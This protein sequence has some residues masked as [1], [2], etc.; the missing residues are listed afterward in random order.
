MIQQYVP[1]PDG[2]EFGLYTLGDHLPDPGTGSRISARQRLQEIISLATL[3]EQAGLDSFSVGE[4][5]Q[6]GF[7]TQAHAVV[8]AAIAQATSRIRIFS[9]STII[10]TSDPVRVFEN[11]ATLDLISGGRA[12]IVA[13]R[14]SRVGL[15]DLLGYDL[16]DYEDLYEEKLALLLKINQEEEVT[17]EGRFRPALRNARVLPRPL[18]QRLPIWRAVGG[19][20]ASAVRAGR[21][22]VPMVL[23]HLGG[24]VQVF[25]R[26]VDV[27]RETASCR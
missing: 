14:A 23:A 5:H 6:E 3:A 7:A 20:P 11:F 27:Y 24:P 22:G 12:E 21:M 25:K 26:L 16:K 18:Q 9:T 1:P 8:L 19:T 15:F 13:G 4:S 17:W 2:L 10:S